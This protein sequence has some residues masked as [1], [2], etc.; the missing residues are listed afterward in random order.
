MFHSHLFGGIFWADS[1][2]M[3]FVQFDDFSMNGEQPVY[4]S[5]QVHKSTHHCFLYWQAN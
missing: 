4:P 5:P 1:L 2:S 3:N